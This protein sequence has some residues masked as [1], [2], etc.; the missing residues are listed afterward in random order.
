MKKLILTIVLFGL[1]NL[2]YAD[3]I[4]A[5][6]DFNEKVQELSGS[7]EQTVKNAKNTQKSSGT[8]AILRP[9][10]FKWTYE[11]PYEQL[12]IGDS[13]YV[14]LYDKDLEQITRRSQANALGASP[15][16]ILSDKKALLHN[17]N[18]QNDGSENNIDYV[19]AT[20]KKN[21]TEYNHIRLGF[22]GIKLVQMQLKDSFGNDIFIKFDVKDNQSKLTAKQFKF[23]PPKG[24]DVLTE[25]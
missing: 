24:V 7:F 23:T 17:Y 21:D 15:A 3:G 1:T 10:Y 11:K 16:A 20:P 4:S 22:N 19:V 2:I 18:L 6:N 14:W 5:I 13:E 9:G 25:E 8:F 12:I